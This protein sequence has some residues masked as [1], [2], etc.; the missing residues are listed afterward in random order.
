MDLLTA[1]KERKRTRKLKK[2]KRTKLQT[3]DLIPEKEWWDAEFVSAP[4][5]FPPLPE[6]V[7][8]KEEVESFHNSNILEANPDKLK[9]IIDFSKINDSVTQFD[10]FP[11]VE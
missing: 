8:T 2:I 3:Q 5:Y 11:E 7:T 10:L 4:G 6:T 1:P 9:E